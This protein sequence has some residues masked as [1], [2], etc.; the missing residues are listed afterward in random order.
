MS[1]ES[2]KHVLIKIEIAIPETSEG[3]QQNLRFVSY[4]T[5][6][7]MVKINSTYASTR[8]LLVELD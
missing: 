2:S 4:Q 6:K 5:P 1:P 3:N 7:M 8:K